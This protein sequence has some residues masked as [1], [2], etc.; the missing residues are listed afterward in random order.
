[1]TPSMLHLCLQV[2][3]NS[4]IRNNWN[5]EPSGCAENLDNWIF[6]WK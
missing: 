5:G 1:M 4:I 6:L 3:W 2:Q